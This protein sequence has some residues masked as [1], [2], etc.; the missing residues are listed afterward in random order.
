MIE[1]I[2]FEVQSPGSDPTADAAITG[3]M[4]DQFKS[5]LRKEDPVLATIFEMNDYGYSSDEIMEHLNMASSSFYYQL[6]R[7]RNR[8]KKFNAD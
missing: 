4:R 5:L 2:N 3:I 1:E 8:W 6:K 7:I